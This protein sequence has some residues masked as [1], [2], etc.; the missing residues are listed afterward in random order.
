MDDDIEIL[1]IF[2]KK[3]TSEVKIVK[4]ETKVISENVDDKD[5]REEKE[6]KAVK[7]SG[8]EKKTKKRKVKAKGIQLLFCTI[9]LLFI[10]GCCVF[11]GIRFFKYYRIFNPKIDSESGE[12]ALANY[13]KFGNSTYSSDGEES[14]GLRSSSGN[15]I[16]FGDVDNNYLK[17]NNM[18]WRIIRVNADNTIEIILDDYVTLLPWNKEATSFGKSDIYEYLNDDF[19]K[20][21]DKDYL[22]KINYCNDKVESLS[23]IKKCE[24]Q[25]SEYVKLLDI[26]TFLNSA[27]DKKSYLV[28]DEEVFWLSDYSTDKVWHTNGTSVSQSGSTSLYEVRPVLK[29]KNTIT[30]S[31]GEGTKE[32]P[33]VIDDETK[34]RVGSKVDLDD[35]IWTVMDI[36][37]KTVKL[38]SDTLLKKQLAYSKSGLDYSESTLKE[39]L[40]T[41]YLE[42]L[43]Y[44]DKLIETTWYVG[45][46]TD[47][48][49]DI[50]EKEDKAKVG[51]P[52]LLDMKFD[53]ELKT[54][55][56][57][58]GTKENI[59][60]YENPIRSSKV[61]MYRYARPCIAISMDTLKDL[62]YEDGV[63]QEEE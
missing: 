34:L 12:T 37:G 9:S 41:T 29:L 15:F 36:D 59:Y 31:K 49:K 35:D 17:F 30:Y 27:K 32:D 7:K 26:T 22:E 50:K 28:E 58:T 19:M 3:K 56:L 40:N 53:N 18:V 51:I 24:N 1:D 45:E 43:S 38:M 46:Y 60:V 42:S 48:I 20:N 23:D 21:I 54:Y 4:T 52:S 57:S 8:K 5:K 39:Y 14:S 16:Y 33:Y 10:I 63:F 13:I 6:E 2:E 61:T 62:K 47:S 25:E 44:N 11:Y 55:F